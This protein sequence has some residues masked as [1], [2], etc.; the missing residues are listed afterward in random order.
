MAHIH[1]RRRQIE[2]SRDVIFDENHA[3]KRSKDI[4]IDFDHKDI[5]LFEEKVHNDKTT[6][7]QKEEEEEEGT[8]EPLQPIIIPETKKMSNWLKATL[9]DAEGH[10]A[11]KGTFRER[12]RPK[13][14]S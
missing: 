1:L 13:R 9:E 10:G 3:Y 4:P 14:Y 6:T 7:K 5:P 11:T 2:V 12:K 8:S